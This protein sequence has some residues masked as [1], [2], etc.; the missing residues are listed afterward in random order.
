MIT[1]GSPW[2]LRWCRCSFGGPQFDAC[3]SQA[4]ELTFT[5]KLGLVQVFSHSLDLAEL[6]T[7]AIIN[8]PLGA[9][10][11]M[12]NLKK[13]TEEEQGKEEQQISGSLA[14]QPVPAGMALTLSVTAPQNTEAEEEVSKPLLSVVLHGESATRMPDPPEANV[15]LKLLESCGAAGDAKGSLGCLKKDE[16]VLGLDVPDD[17]GSSTCPGSRRSP[18]SSESPIAGFSDSS[19]DAETDEED[20]AQP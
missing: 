16:G 19:E 17:D 14:T 12:L 2:G 20:H 6:Q 9:G 1:S 8:L 3:Q 5:A 18:A 10:T 13:K 11:I 7:Q 4:V 15:W